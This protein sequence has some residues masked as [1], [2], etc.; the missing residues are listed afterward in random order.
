[1]VADSLVTVGDYRLTDTQKVR[2]VDAGKH[3]V[4]LIAMS[5]DV[6]CHTIVADDI[7][8]F[9]L[10]KDTGRGGP[11]TEEEFD[12][13]A[14]RQFS[15]LSVSE[16]CSV[17]VVKPS[18]AMSFFAEDGFHGHW[19]G[20]PYSIGCASQFTNGAMAAGASALD[21]VRLACKHNTACGGPLHVYLAGKGY[22]TTITI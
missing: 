5:G 14:S 3:G 1:M 11:L 16:S 19:R 18:G 13:R 12:R 20:I 4:W 22:D 21:A 7:E 6:G 8:D 10:Q 9:I 17:L 2:V 15:Q